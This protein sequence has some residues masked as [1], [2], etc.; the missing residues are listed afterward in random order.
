MHSI[1]SE[2]GEKPMIRNRYNRIS[3]AESQDDNSLPAD[4]HQVILNKM[5]KKSKANI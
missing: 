4:G 1:I 3:Q 2:V 5:N